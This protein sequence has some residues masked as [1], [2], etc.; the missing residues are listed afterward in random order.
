MAVAVRRGYAVASTD[1]GH[2]GNG[3]DGSFAFNHPEKLI[4]FGY[5]AVHEMTIQGKAIA[6]SH[7]GAA[8]RLWYWNGCSTGGRQGLME[9]Q[10]YPADY[11]AM[12][13]GAPANYMTHM[14]SQ[15]LW[16]GLATLKNPA[17]FIPR[18]KYALIHDAAIQACDRNDGVADGV[19]EDPAACT[20]DP[21]ALQCAGDDGSSCLTAPQVEAARNI[22]SSLRH[23][24]TGVEIF[25]GLE[26]GSEKGWGAL[27]GGPGP[28]SIAND[29]FRFVVFKNPAWDF[30]TLDFAK[31]VAVAE[32]ID[33]GT[34]DAVDPNLR[35]FFSRGGKVLMYHGW[36]DQLISPRNSINY[37]TNVV[38][39]A[40]ADSAADS[41]RLFMVPGMNHCMGGDGVTNFDPLDIL[42]QWVEKEDA[43]SIVAARANGSVVRA[44]RP[45]P[46][47]AVTRAAAARM[48]PRTLSA[49]FA[50]IDGGADQLTCASSRQPSDYFFAVPASSPIRR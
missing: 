47:V 5:R 45:Y 25:P 44:P 43:G 1:T 39:T 36:N 27:A 19:L 23:P 21:K 49:K 3:G 7:Y 17:S 15:S 20:F 13:T 26:R 10:R 50:E 6:T 32:K 41:I 18:E 28:L 2:A 24:A 29:Y 42:Q 31:D 35:P 40:G 16:V 37:Y 11:D 48:K 22:Y 9:A 14:Q 38:K 33:N 4:D 30:K 34:L 8:P 12:V 46:Q